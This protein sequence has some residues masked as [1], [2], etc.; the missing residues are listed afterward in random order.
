MT[1]L[2]CN[3]KTMSKA[4]R[5]LEETVGKGNPIEESDIARLP[6]LQA[7]IKETFRLHPS[8]PFLLPRK[9]DVDVQVSGY[10]IP[11]G[12]QLLI[13]VWAIG[14][15]ESIWNNPKVF[16]PERFLGSE[17]DFKGR[18]LELI[19]HLMVVGEC[20]LVCHLR[21]GCWVH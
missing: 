11:K 10:T 18:H 3:P 9:A 1:E 19:Y 4:K 14:R 16:S 5:E 13:N 6:Y 2:L 21:G 8:V 20:V 17:I 12:S 15:D 7:I